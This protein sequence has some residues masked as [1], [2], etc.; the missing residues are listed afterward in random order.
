MRATLDNQLPS[1]TFPFP[2]NSADKWDP[3]GGCC[4]YTNLMTSGCQFSKM[5]S[6]EE[7]QGD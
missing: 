4:T 2:Y 7:K 3:I 6:V 1:I 5:F